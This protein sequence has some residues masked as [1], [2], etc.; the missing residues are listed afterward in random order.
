MRRFLPKLAFL[1]LIAFLF[2]S[3][4]PVLAANSKQDIKAMWSVLK[5][6]TYETVFDISPS[7]A[8]P[9][10]AGKLHA[11]YLQNGLNMA[12][13][14]RYIAGL[15]YDLPLD[16]TLLTMAQHGAVLLAASDELSHSPARP[17]AMEDAFYDKA[18]WSTTG[19]NISMT[20]SL[21]PSLDDCVLSYLSDSD[22]ANI[23]RLEHRR[24]ILNPPLLKTAFGLAAGNHNR[25]YST[26]HVF[27]TSRANTGSFPYVAWP[28]SGYFP[29][30]FFDYTDAWSCSLD[31]KIYSK[32]AAEYIT[33]K[34]TRQSTGQVWNFSQED[35]DVS[36][37]YFNVETSGYGTDFCIIFRP[38]RL[39]MIGDEA[40]DVEISSLFKGKSKNETLSYTVNFFSLENQIKLRIGSPLMNIKGQKIE[41]DPGRGTV[42]MIYNDRTYLPIR[43]LIESLGGKVGWQDEN[44]EVSISLGDKSIKLSVGNEKAYVNGNETINKDCP[45][46]SNDRVLVPVRFITENLGFQVDWNP[47]KAEVIISGGM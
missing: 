8:S 45:M 24:W 26:M 27:D 30:E 14:A 31:S 28:A 22:P 6:A 29:T 3:C 1:S 17:P 43:A 39:G 5:P 46:I 2:F 37:K 32:E 20:P 41:I 19:S 12:N 10:Q 4:P 40:F 42:P 23:N 38:D 47:N 15:P 25:Y 16:D 36:G 7:I 34:L 33:V 21:L 11:D 13:F 18:I 44:Q 9:Y 35:K